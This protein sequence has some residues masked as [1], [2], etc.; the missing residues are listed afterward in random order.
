MNCSLCKEEYTPTATTYQVAV[1]DDDARNTLIVFWHPR[2]RKHRM[3][4]R[5]IKDKL[6]LLTY[7]AIKPKNTNS[8]M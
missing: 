6:E 4:M 3:C 7:H 5:I 1:K 2:K 8:L